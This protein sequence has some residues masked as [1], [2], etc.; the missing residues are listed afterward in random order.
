MRHNPK[1]LSFVFY[2]F[3]IIAVCLIGL[4]NMAYLAISHYW[5]YTDMGYKSFCALSHSVN[6]DTVSQSPYSILLGIPVPIWG[7]GA[8]LF[9][10]Y[11]LFLAGTRQTKQQRMWTLLFWISV[12]F[13]IYSLIL[14]GISSFLIDSYC[15]MCI[16]GYLVNFF[17]LYYSWFIN[18]RFGDQGLIRGV[19]SDIRFI[20]YNRNSS[21]PVIGLLFL[22]FLTGPF[23]FP[24]YWHL[25]EPKPAHA[26][27]RGV[28]D[29]GHPWIGAEDPTL[30]IEEFTDYMCFQ[31]RKM[32]YHL[33]RLA[34][35]HPQKIRLVHRHF[36][37]DHQY[38]PLVRKPY[39]TGAGKLALVAI[40]AQDKGKF[41]ESND[42]LYNLGTRQ[43]KIQIS[44]IASALDL[45][46]EEIA[47]GLKDQD[48]LSRLIYDIKSG[49][50]LGIYATPSYVIN[51]KLYQGHIPPEQLTEAMK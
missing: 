20:I 47:G 37:M 42:Y 22:F 48:C 44:D 38:N 1:P 10:L 39:H 2:Y 19:A 5:V 36:P 18:R 25:Q 40:T 33:R 21:V 27:P 28:T 3:P 31:C 24:Q 15:L 50:K 49:L 51:D 23:W 43:G 46:Q 8:Y 26:L 41:W 17:L 7:M 16:L 4:C 32:H 34:E 45:K 12:G 30:V 11:L 35:T 6:C 29:D 9:T 13:S 14:A